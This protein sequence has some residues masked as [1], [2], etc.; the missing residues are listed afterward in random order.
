[1][2]EFGAIATRL[3]L[4]GTR[5]E[6]YLELARRARERRDPFTAET[7]YQRAVLEARTVREA[8]RVAEVVFLSWGAEDDRYFRPMKRQ[9]IEHALATAIALADSQA[10]LEWL[11]ERAAWMAAHQAL[12]AIDRR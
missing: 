3:S 1:M 7:I 10:E 8:A 5:L 9:I 6:A 4:P 12:E 2:K 11:R